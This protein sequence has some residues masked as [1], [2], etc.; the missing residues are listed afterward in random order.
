VLDGG[1]S[2]GIECGI[3]LR[4]A[5]V[6]AW[7]MIALAVDAATAISVWYA[8]KCTRGWLESQAFLD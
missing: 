1:E 5:Y 4:V 2:G 8:G 7:V 3:A 6:G